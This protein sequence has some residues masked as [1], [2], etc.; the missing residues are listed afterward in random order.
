MLCDVC[1]TDVQDGIY[2]RRGIL[3]VVY[4]RQPSADAIL[5]DAGR[6]PGDGV[7]R[8]SSM[9]PVVSDELR[10]SLGE[11]CTPLLAATTVGKRLDMARLFFKLEAKNPTG[12]FKDRESA[13]ALSAAK[14]LGAT[15]VAAASTGTLAASLAAYA[16]RGSIP[17][18]VFVPASAPR[19]KLAQMQVYG[20]QVVTVRA[21]YE[22]VLALLSQACV[23]HGWRNCSSAVDPYR[24]EGDK[25]IAAET[26]EQL[27][28]RAPDW[29][30]IPTGGGGDL[31][32]QWHGYRELASAGLIDTPPKMASIGVAAGASLAHAVQ[33]GLP[34]VA[35]VPVGPTVAGSLLSAY[36]DYGILALAAIRDS[37]GTAVAVSEQAL[38]DCQRELACLEGLF[39]EPSAAVALAGLKQLLENNVVD[40]QE[41]VVLVLTGDG[42]RDIDAARSQIE[43]PA[44][45]DDSGEEVARLGS[46]LGG[47]TGSTDTERT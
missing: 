35:A 47:R 18:A 11:G 5:N 7:W 14:A 37:G 42:L 39:V 45:I 46:S 40:P 1:P 17:A 21:I 20:A 3:E 41:T 31:A 36:A 12:A 33:E 10:V 6:P 28:W 23:Q 27:G 22:R 13:V 32:G 25:P 2:M 30:V 4:E 24:I 19:E 16:A 44:V 43:S 34:E 38:L 15:T 8:F 29:V 9:L 26:C